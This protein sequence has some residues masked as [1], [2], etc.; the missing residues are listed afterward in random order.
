MQFGEEHELFRRSLRRF[1][2]EEIAPHVDEW[3]E[4]EEIPR[5][6]FR[7]MGELGFLGLEYPREYGGAGADFDDQPIARYHGRRGVAIV[8][9]RATADLSASR[10]TILV[11]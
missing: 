9:A 10:D 8:P 7:R 6:L 3:E 1:V 11:V 5:E 4:L 2:Q